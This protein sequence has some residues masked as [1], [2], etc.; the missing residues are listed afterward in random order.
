M[1]NHEHEHVVH[2]YASTDD[3]IRMIQALKVAGIA[4]KH[5]TVISQDEEVA[6]TVADTT[7]ARAAQVP[8]ID[9]Q[10]ASAFGR[11]LAAGHV[12][13]VV[14]AGEQATLAARIMRD[15]LVDG[16]GLYAERDES[17]FVDTS[18]GSG[19][20]VATSTGT[21]T[22]MTPGGGYEPN[23]GSGVA[24]SGGTLGQFAPGADTPN[25]DD[26]FPA[27]GNG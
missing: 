15:G 8:G 16:A 7:G 2:E 6:R 18:T 17:V 10:R 9:E 22:G 25:L 3:A 1:S 27:R 12:A 26:D 13:V 20:A 23:T 24:T 11:H 4:E 21:A 19:A 5:I 14:E